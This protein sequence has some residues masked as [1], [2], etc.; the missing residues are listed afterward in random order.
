MGRQ[1]LSPDGRDAWKE[2][3]GTKEI[4]RAENINKYCPCV[5]KCIYIVVTTVEFLDISA[6]TNSFMVFLITV[7]LENRSVIKKRLN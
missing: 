6:V 2:Q 1:L 3:P 7:S 5:E 4:Q